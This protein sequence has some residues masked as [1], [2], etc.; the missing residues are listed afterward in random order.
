[1]GSPVASLFFIYWLHDTKSKEHSIIASLI[2]KSHLALSS[3]YLISP[4]PR[5][6]EA[7]LSLSPP[8]PP[9]SLPYLHFDKLLRQSEAMAWAGLPSPSGRGA[10]GEGVKSLLA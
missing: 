7:S 9:P 8:E 3:P 6:G 10:G 4:Y 1:M 5:S 2:H